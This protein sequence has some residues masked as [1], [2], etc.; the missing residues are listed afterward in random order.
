EEQSEQM[1]DLLEHIGRIF[2]IPQQKREVVTAAINRLLDSDEIYDR[3]I[4]K[5]FIQLL[6]INDERNL[7]KKLFSIPN[8][9]ISASILSNSIQLVLKEKMPEPMIERV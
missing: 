1:F 4:S 8:L 9:A 6:L 2:F 7:I 5:D 3:E